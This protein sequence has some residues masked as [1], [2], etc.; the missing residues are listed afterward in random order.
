MY[1][2]GFLYEV[3]KTIDRKKRFMKMRIEKRLEELGVCLPTPPTPLA[4]YIVC[5]QIG[6]LV[7]VSGQ[8]PIINGEQ[9]YTGKV[10]SDI[11]DEDGYQAARC[12]AIN[13]VAQLKHFLG[14]LDCVKQ[15]VHLKGYVASDSGFY[16]QPAVINGASDFMV[17]VFGKVGLH[18]RCALGVNVLPSNISVEVELI[19]EV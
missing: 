12:C 9:L 15:V 6:N 3:A 1:K 19:V 11:S 5:K 18:T 2:T 17:D 7:F 16:A 10:G 14:N 4:N 13:L 8:G